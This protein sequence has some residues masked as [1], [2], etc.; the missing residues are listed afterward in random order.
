[1]LLGTAGVG[2]IGIYTS[3]INIVS[4]LSAMGLRSSGVR[5]IASAR[6]AAD[7]ELIG[8]LQLA[9]SRVILI[10]ALIAVIFLAV[11]SQWLSRLVFDGSESGALP[12][13]FLGLAIIFKGLNLS[14]ECS[15]RGFRK[16]G[17]FARISI[18]GALISALFAVA[19]YLWIG[20]DG[21][22]PV[23]VITAAVNYILAW[24]FS[25]KL[26]IRSKS[27]SWAT[28]LVHSRR[29]IGLGA[30]VAYGSMLTN[31]PPLVARSLIVT[32]IGLAANGLYSAA[33]VISGMFA[34]FILKAMSADFF[35]RLS[36]HSDDPEVVNQLVSE[37][38]E[39]GI[40]I[41]LP[42]ILVTTAFAPLALRVLFTAEFTPAADLLPWLLL[43]VFARVVNWPMGM[44]M[45]AHGDSKRFAF[46]QTV[47]VCV[48]IGLIYSLFTYVGLIGAVMGFALI[49]TLCCPGLYW[50]LSSKYDFR[51]ASAVAPL[52][53][54][55]LT[56]FGSITLIRIY[57]FEGILF[58]CSAVGIILLGGGFSLYGLLRRL[59][60]NPRLNKLLQKLP[61]G[62]TRRFKNRI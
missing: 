43:G 17:D 5:E 55:S 51:W 31:V 59:E 39:I 4:T 19:I 48:H 56:F 47:S 32:N 60:G 46:T 50:F 6:G 54:I 29:L 15:I 13:A 24:S 44:I 35:P 61:D 18:I 58:Y 45:L 41:A 23:I 42:G 33:W 14:Q 1:V 10:L 3:V 7:E 37:Q 20:I 53:L 36:E 30:A 16:I 49:N 11:A 62:I 2:L 26:Q 12:I 8:Q 28:T 40:L 9:I 25:R 52:L 22:V 27:T 38:T 21:V 57:V 34:Q